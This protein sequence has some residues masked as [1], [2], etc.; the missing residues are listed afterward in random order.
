MGKLAFLSV[1]AG[2]AFEL[3]S[4]SVALHW[5]GRAINAILV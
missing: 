1:V 3:I 2:S 5:K 4:M